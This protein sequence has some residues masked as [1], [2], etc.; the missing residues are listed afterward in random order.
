MAYQLPCH[1]LEVFS[2]LPLWI[3]EIQILVALYM[4]SQQKK[5]GNLKINKLCVF[6]Y[7]YINKCCI[8]LYVAIYKQCKQTIVAI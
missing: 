6:L 4:E 1:V 7:T 5:A 3:S 2:R 8:F